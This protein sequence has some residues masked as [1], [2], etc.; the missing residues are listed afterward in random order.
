LGG[1]DADKTYGLSD[2]NFG[3]EGENM[4][5]GGTHLKIVVKEGED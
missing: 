5:A 1:P 2:G 4:I 3:G